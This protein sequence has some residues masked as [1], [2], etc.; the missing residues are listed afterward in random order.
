LGTAIVALEP[1]FTYANLTPEQAQ[2]LK[3]LEIE[4]GVI[5]LAYDTES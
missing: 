2:E 5:L 4:L 1:K 3:A